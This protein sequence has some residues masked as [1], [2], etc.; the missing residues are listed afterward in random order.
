MVSA[1]FDGVNLLGSPELIG[2]ALPELIEG[3]KSRGL[4]FQPRNVSFFY[5]NADNHAWAG[6]MR[7]SSE[8]T[9]VLGAA[10]GT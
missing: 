5:H 1:Y 3:F 9:L 4:Q 6:E 10:I 7:R 2:E 8:G